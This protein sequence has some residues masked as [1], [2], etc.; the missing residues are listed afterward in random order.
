MNFTYTVTKPA[1][2]QWGA[3][4]K[5]GSWNGMIGLLATEKIDIG[6]YYLFI[7]TYCLT[8][9]CSPLGQKN[10]NLKLILKFI[11]YFT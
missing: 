9:Q 5:D 8:V 10:R 6:N 11:P 2:R 1:D 3:I 7:I 4:Q